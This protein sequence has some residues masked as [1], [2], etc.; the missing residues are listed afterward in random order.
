M[1]D[2][3][4]EIYEAED[5]LNGKQNLVDNER[6]DVVPVKLEEVGKLLNEEKFGARSKYALRSFVYK[7]KIKELER[8]VKALEEKLDENERGE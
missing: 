6:I 1:T 7:Q 5:K 8:Q 4:A 3:R 2:E